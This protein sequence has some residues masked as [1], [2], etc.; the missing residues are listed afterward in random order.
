MQNKE[1]TKIMAHLRQDPVMRHL[2]SKVTPKQNTSLGDMYGD[3][4][5]AISSQQISVKAA[6]AIH[7]RFLDFYDGY[8]PTP[9]QLLDTDYDDLRAVGLSNQ[10][11]GYMFNIAAYW[12]EHKLHLQDWAS[13]TDQEI[14]DL[15]LPIKGVG[16]WTIQMLLMFTLE[17]PDVFPIDDLAIQQSMIKH[18]K[19]SYKSKKEMKLKLEKIATAWSPYRSTACIYLFRSRDIMPMG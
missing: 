17:R 9:D 10:K 18:Y 15:L 3:L 4:L 8:V 19:V 14:I 2:I 7:Q 5:Y 6:K 11:T 16:K 13:M 12:K 1:W